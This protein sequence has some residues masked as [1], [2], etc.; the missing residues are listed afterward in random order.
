MKWT[1]KFGIPEAL[2]NA[3]RKDTY[4]K[5][6]DIS[7]TSLIKPPRIRILEKRHWNEIEQDV[8]DAMWRLLGQAMHYVISLADVKDGLQ[9]EALVVNVDGWQISGRPDLYREGIITDWKVTSVW[10]FVYGLKSEWEQQLNCYAFLYRSYGFD[11]SGLQ[12]YCIL[13]DFQKQRSLRENDYPKCPFANITVPLWDENKVLDFIKSRIEI[14]RN[15]EKLED[16]DLPRCTKEEM[17]K[18]EDQ[19]AV[20]KRTQK[21]AVKILTSLEEAK[22]FVQG[23]TD[24]EIEFREGEAIRCKNYCLVNKFCNQ[25]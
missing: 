22:K 7:I 21:R 4:E 23:N 19:F 24:Y 12:I 14:H 3:I 6:G 15:S 11:V 18:R 20:K 9:E 1:N 10:S 25:V 16:K 2:Y 8:S 17:W 5:I 13:R